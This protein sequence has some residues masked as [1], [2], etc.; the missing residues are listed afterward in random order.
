M[1]NKKII[2]SI[3]LIIACLSLMSS[4]LPQNSAGQQNESLDKDSGV[5]TT[6]EING[7]DYANTITD[8]MSVYDFM[9][10]LRA[11]GKINF[12][13]QNYAGMGKFIQSI[14]GISGNENEAW[15]YYVNGQEAQVGVS[16]YKIK[17]GDLVSFKY[18][19]SNY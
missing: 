13:E 9:S 7:V 12:I 16:N 1:K 17:P 19:K 2:I 15:I 11:E 5:K 6:L 18:E 10:Q 3:V 8:Q 4:S 14:N